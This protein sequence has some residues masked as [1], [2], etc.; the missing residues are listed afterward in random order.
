MA[1]GVVDVNTTPSSQTPLAER[2]NGSRWS[3]VRTPK[4]PPFPNGSPGSEYFKVVS[5]PTTKV[6]IAAGSVWTDN[7]LLVARWNG[8][9][10]SIEPTPSYL[11]PGSYSADAQGLSCATVTQCLLVPAPLRLDGTGWIVAPHP[12]GVIGLTGVSC[13]SPTVCIGVGSVD[14]GYPIDDPAA[15]TW[16]RVERYS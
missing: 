14:N 10:W 8:L 11:G 5:C 16:T 15:R 12:V 1:V 4:A 9:A 3:L 6:C 7:P 13:V 2:W